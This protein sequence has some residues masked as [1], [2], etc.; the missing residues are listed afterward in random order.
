[1]FGHLAR[2]D[3]TADARRILT[4][5]HQS[6]WIGQ[7]RPYTSWIATLKS[8][9]PLYNFTFEDAI[10]LAL[11]KSLWRLRSYALTLCMPNNDDDDDDVSCIAVPKKLKRVAKSGMQCGKQAIQPNI[12]K[13][14][15]RRGPASIVGG[16]GAK[17][18][19]WPWMCYLETFIGSNASLCGAT[20]IDRMHVLTAAH[21]V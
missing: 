3:E 5:V 15:P 17:P 16:T 14:T 19:S 18:N 9:L 6:D 2:T 20:V 13:I 7:W 8:D 4:G 1:L 11:D 21:C 12:P 10:E